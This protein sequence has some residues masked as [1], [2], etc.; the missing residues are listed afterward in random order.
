MRQ[1][2]QIQASAKLGIAPHCGANKE[3]KSVNLVEAELVLYCISE[4]DQAKIHISPHGNL[5]FTLN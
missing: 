1:M 4:T 2:T 3:R 5:R